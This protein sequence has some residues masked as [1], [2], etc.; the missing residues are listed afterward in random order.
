LERKWIFGT[1][2][3][4]WHRSGYL[5]QKWIFGIEVDIWHRSGYLTQ[6]WIFDTE[7]MG[8]VRMRQFDSQNRRK[9]ID[10]EKENTSLSWT[11]PQ[12]RRT[13]IHDTPSHMG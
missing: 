1:E 7:R 10:V 6:K 13:Q 12:A 9:K 8:S 3:D 11:L 4:I 5:A 2:V